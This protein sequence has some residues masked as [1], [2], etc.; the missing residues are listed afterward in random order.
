MAV[1]LNVGSATHRWGVEIEDI[2]NQ[3]WC[4]C[5]MKIH[6]LTNKLIGS[7][8]AGSLVYS[9]RTTIQAC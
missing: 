7:Y 6:L 3:S 2:M 8:K 1:V 9:Y 4:E 5:K